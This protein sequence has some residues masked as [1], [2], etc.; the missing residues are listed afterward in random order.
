MVWSYRTSGR[1]ILNNN[2]FYDIVNLK[3]KYNGEKLCIKILNMHLKK[4][5]SWY[6]IYTY[7]TYINKTFRG[8]REKFR[9]HTKTG[10]LIYAVHFKTKTKLSRKVKKY[11]CTNC[12]SWVAKTDI[13]TDLLH[14]VIKKKNNYLRKYNPTNYIYMA[15]LSGTL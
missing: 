2:C 10:I 7:F 9:Q 12:F 5:F 8:K 3:K 13:E 14:K 4:L 1:T 15:C 11:S 6:I